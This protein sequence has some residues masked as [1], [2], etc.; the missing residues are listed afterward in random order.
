MGQQQKPASKSH[1]GYRDSKLTRVLQPSLSGNAKL[2]FICCITASGLF[3]EETKST[4]QFAQRIKHVKTASKINLKAANK[5]DVIKRMQDDLDDAKQSLAESLDKVHHLKNEIE[6]LKLKNKS[7]TNERDRALKLV[8]IHEKKAKEKEKAQKNIRVP[9]DNTGGKPPK[10][11]HSTKKKNNIDT[12]LAQTSG[13]IK[14]LNEANNDI[15]NQVSFLAE[16]ADQLQ[17]RKTIR[18]NGMP[19][20]VR[21]D[22]DSGLISEITE[23]TRYGT[24]IDEIDISHYSFLSEEQ[25]KQ[26]SNSSLISKGEFVQG[27]SHLNVITEV[28]PT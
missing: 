10:D 1:I 18:V 17:G 7:L 23:P 14:A 16:F 26:S 19:S 22:S 3:L 24:H 21:T 25:S 11:I 20:H 4:L 9:Q 2:A 8:K 6:T 13:D 12:N 5:N 28:L 15:K 27:E